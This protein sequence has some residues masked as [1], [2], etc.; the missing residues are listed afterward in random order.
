MKVRSQSFRSFD[1][2]EFW[3]YNRLCFVFYIVLNV[4]FCLS[5]TCQNVILQFAY[6]GLNTASSEN[7][8]TPRQLRILL[9]VS[10]QPFNCLS[11]E[12]K[13]KM[14]QGESDARSFFLKK[15]NKKKN[16]PCR[17]FPLMFFHRSSIWNMWLGVQFC[18][19]LVWV[20]CKR[21]CRCQMRPAYHL[22]F[23]SSF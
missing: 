9:R 3:S 1:R 23:R 15:N 5:K 21:S 18:A 14:G 6:C 16:I 20:I 12:K 8:F 11:P 7:T 10:A 17:S 13:K 4:C 22:W 19:Y 2:R